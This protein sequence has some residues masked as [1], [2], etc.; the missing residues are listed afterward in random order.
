MDAALKI[1][2]EDKLGPAFVI[3]DLGF[4]DGEDDEGYFDEGCS[5]K[6]PAGG[7]ADDDLDDDEDDGLKDE[8]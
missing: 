2:V 4:G 8:P 5:Y 3:D 6:I 1:A 7:G